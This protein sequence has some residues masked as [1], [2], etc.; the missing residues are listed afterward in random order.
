MSEV[1]HDSVFTRGHVVSGLFVLFLER[2]E[3]VIRGKLTA[4]AAAAA[5]VSR[6]NCFGLQTWV[7]DIA[8]LDRRACRFTLPESPLFLATAS[9]DVRGSSQLSRLIF[10]S[11]RF[12]FCFTFQ[13]DLRRPSMARTSGRRV[14]CCRG[15]TG[16][17][18]RG[19]K[20]VIMWLFRRT[21]RV[22]YLKIL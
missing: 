17:K 9:A 15:T 14:T 18:K 10:G 8:D 16:T 13:L 4:A 7:D 3:T 11:C 22:Y 6:R 1:K 5:S 12:Y 20:R 19:N 21:E 2:K